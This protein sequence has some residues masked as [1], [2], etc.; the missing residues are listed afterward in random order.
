MGFLKWSMTAV[1]AG[2]LR[3]DI[4]SDQFPVLWCVFMDL[5][6]SLGV[7]GGRWGMRKRGMRRRGTSP[8]S[9]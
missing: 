8:H 4:V 9:V 3:P 5:F 7:E 1:D 2:S 6:L